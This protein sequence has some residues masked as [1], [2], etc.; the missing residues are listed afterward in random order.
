MS[1]NL[2]L[3]LL[4]CIIAGAWVIVRVVDARA[5]LRRKQMADE[6]VARLDASSAASFERVARILAGREP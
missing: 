6:L 5:A 2:A 1:N 4:A 3:V